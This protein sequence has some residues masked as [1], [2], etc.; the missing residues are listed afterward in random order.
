MPDVPRTS[1]GDGPRVGS[2]KRNDDGRLPEVP[3]GSWRPYGL[4]D[5][6]LLAGRELNARNQL[7]MW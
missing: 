1:P 5:V 2:H 6:S 7:S 4:P 3:H